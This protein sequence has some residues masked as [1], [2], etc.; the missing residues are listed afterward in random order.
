MCGL[1][2]GEN[3]RWV[4]SLATWSFSRR[5]W[6][7]TTSLQGSFCCRWCV[8]RTNIN[9]VILRQMWRDS[10][11]PETMS[12][13][14]GFLSIDLLCSEAPT[15][16][17][18]GDEGNVNV[19]SLTAASSVHCEQNQC[20]FNGAHPWVTLTYNWFLNFLFTCVSCLP[21]PILI[22]QNTIFFA[23]YAHRIKSQLQRRIGLF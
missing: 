8:C 23:A 18:R 22:T 5:C 7:R 15:V 19:P 2:E 1:I 11:R 20:N 16:S 10:E 17:R 3:S 4:T 21:F 6:A 12:T 13:Q 14:G 9:D